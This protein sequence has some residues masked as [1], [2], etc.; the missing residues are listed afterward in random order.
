MELNN[1]LHH[2]PWKNMKLVFNREMGLTDNEVLVSKQLYG[3]NKI[4]EKVK[5]H[6]FLKFLH[7]FTNL[8]SILLQLGSI[9]CFV[10]YGLDTTLSDFLYLG[11]V[12]Y[13]VVILTSF[14]SFYQAS[15]SESIMNSF[16]NLLPD[17]ARLIRNGEYIEIESNEVVMGDTILLDLGDKIN[18]DVR[19]FES[20][21]MKVD[22]SILTGESEPQLRCETTNDPNILESSNM[23]FFGTTVVEGNGKGIVIGIG[24]KTEMGKIAGL[25]QNTSQVLTPIK[26]EIQYF[27]KIISSIA[28]T[29]GVI[30]FGLGFVKKTSYIVNII[31]CIGI[32]VANVPE[33]LLATVTIILALAAKQMANKKVLV[34]NLETVE[35]LGSTSVICTDKTGTLTKNK[36]TVSHIVFNGKVISAKKRQENI[37]EKPYWNTLLAIGFR[38]NKARQLYNCD[39]TKYYVGNPT[40]VALKSWISPQLDFKKYITILDIPFDSKKKYQLLIIKNDCLVEFYL[41]G[42]YDRIIDFCHNTYHNDKISP[43]N[44]NKLDEMSLPLANNGERILGFAYK[45][46]QYDPNYEFCTKNLPQILKNFTFYGMISFQDPPRDNVPWAVSECQKAGV[47]VVMVTGDHPITA[48]SIGK[49]TNILHRDKEL[50]KE[51]LLLN[52]DNI[53]SDFKERDFTSVVVTGKTIPLLQDDDWTY[54]LSKQELIFARTS[55]EQKLQIVEKFQNMGKVVAV[56]GDGVNDSPALKKADIGIAMGI[57]GSD[58]SKETADMILLDDNFASIVNG[59]KEGRRVFENL[60][61]SI[62]Y[63]LSSNIPEICPFLLFIILNIPLPLTTVLIL[64]I[65]LGTDMIPA[66][67]FAWEPTESDLMTQPPRIMGKDRLVDFNLISFSYLQIGVLQA[68]AAFFTYFYVFHRE[69]FPINVLPGLGDKFGEED[70]YCV[71]ENDSPKSCGYDN[72]GQLFKTSDE[73]EYILKVAQT[74]YFTTII[75]VQVSDKII[76]KTRRLSLFQHCKFNYADLAGF[77]SELILGILLTYVPFLNTGLGTE[78]LNWEYWIISIP[79]AIYIFFYDELRKLVIRNISKKSLIYKLLSW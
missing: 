20:N 25:A 50:N 10:G 79:F 8:F 66:I 35:S 1:K 51:I 41:K 11:I 77:S 65:D 71:F 34:K 47:Q 40:D 15:K 56:T 7:E 19:L 28:I 67:S 2:L 58:V 59:I 24:D 9:L 46:E 70:L 72:V 60:K 16:K 55:P 57:N 12:L 29:L 62:A 30:F 49:Q 6:P 22:N 38:C 23:V 48:I 68:I 36:L 44:T 45:M 69:G 37:K 78:A 42:A 14:F 32:I 3:G 76:C 54:I 33:G 5:T 74:A 31:N 64:F 13:V 17:K 75:I 4:T 18:A 27:V 73:C 53:I 43:I 26:R 63:T 21:D 52:P 61:K 39:K